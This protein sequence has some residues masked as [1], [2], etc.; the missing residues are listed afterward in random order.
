MDAHALTRRFGPLIATHCR[1]SQILHERNII[2]RPL[3]YESLTFHAS[4]TSKLTPVLMDIPSTPVLSSVFIALV[5][6]SRQVEKT[7]PSPL[8]ISSSSIL[9]VSIK[10]DDK[11]TLVSARNNIYMKISDVAKLFVSEWLCIN[12]SIVSLLL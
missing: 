5:T 8:I 2:L 10:D 9:F 7:T 3:A 4:A 11:R 1:I 6:S 12:D